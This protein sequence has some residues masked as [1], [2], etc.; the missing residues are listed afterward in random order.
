MSADTGNGASVTFSTYSGTLA[1]ID[2]DLGEQSIGTLDATVLASQDFKKYIF[3]DL[4]ETNEVTMT[5]QWDT[6][7]TPPAC[8]GVPETVTITFP[9][10]TGETAAANL[11]G[12]GAFT[13]V[14][15]PMLAN[16]EVQQGEITVKFDGQ[17]GP[18]YTAAT[19]A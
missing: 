7:E 5:V 2:I 8:D 13:T 17:T 10:R 19:T 1:V 14:K 9:Q 3:E 11:A 6:T 15:Y 4:A 16:S 18:T 12:T